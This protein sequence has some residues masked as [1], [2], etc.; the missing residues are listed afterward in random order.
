MSEYAEKKLTEATLRRSSGK[1]NKS[2]WDQVVVVIDEAM[3]DQRHA[4]AE[5]LL[6]RYGKDEAYQL[7]MNANVEVKND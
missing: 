4:C 1:E 6:T 5:A 7:V 2:M 3:R